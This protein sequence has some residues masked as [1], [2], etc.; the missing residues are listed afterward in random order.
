MVQ[1]DFGPF[2]RALT[3]EEK[4]MLRSV[5]VVFT[6]SKTKDSE[7]TLLGRRPDEPEVLLLK[8][9]SCSTY[10]G[11]GYSSSNPGR[12]AAVHCGG[13]NVRYGEGR[14]RGSYDTV[15]DGIAGN[16][17]LIA[18]ASELFGNWRSNPLPETLYAIRSMATASKRGIRPDAE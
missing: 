18:K 16:R 7:A 10:L 11:R 14:V 13:K 6:S 8:F 17:T 15:I 1:D 5:P 4:T 3:A 9:P 2:P 12:V